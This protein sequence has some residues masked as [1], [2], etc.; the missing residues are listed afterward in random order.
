[1][2]IKLKNISYSYKHE[3][4]KNVS[5][6]FK[7][8]LVTVI[9]GKNGVGKTTFFNLLTNN[10]TLK[11][12]E[13]LFSI[14]DTTSNELKNNLYG[15]MSSEFFY[16]KQLTLKEMCFLV[17]ELRELNDSFFGKQYEKYLSLFSLKEYEHKLIGK[18]SLGTQKRLHLLLTILHNPSFI[19][20]D[21]PTSG[22]D[23]QQVF[24]FKKLIKEIS[25]ENKIIILSTHSLELAKELADE[26][27]I[28]NNATFVNVPVDDNLENNYLS[29]VK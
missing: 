18:L 7:S 14:D 3:I 5:Q 11:S 27:V 17:K 28:L 2:S 22:L 6:E 19:F 10:L 20:L 4:L 16:Y 23:P 1:M 9:L 21:E 13:I 25:S 26:I 24:V 8:G 29:I 15:Y 12:G